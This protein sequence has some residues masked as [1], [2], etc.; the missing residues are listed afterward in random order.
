ML[1]KKFVLTVK[2]QQICPRGQL[3]SPH[4]CQF[5]RFHHRL[6]L[7]RYQNLSVTF[8]GIKRICQEAFDEFQT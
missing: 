4:Q 6:N 7:K 3:T 8:G 2:L 5:S 1:S